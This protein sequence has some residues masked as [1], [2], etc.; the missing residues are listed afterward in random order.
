MKDK[1]P[2]IRWNRKFEF[3]NNCMLFHLF[4]NYPQFHHHSHTCQYLVGW[5]WAILQLLLK[6]WKKTFSRFIN[7]G[8]NKGI[9]PFCRGPSSIL[10][11][12]ETIFKENI[13]LFNIEKPLRPTLTKIRTYI[14]CCF[15]W[16]IFSRLSTIYM[17][18]K[19]M[20]FPIYFA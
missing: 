17:G 10:Y 20:L 2:W 4:L 15:L 14:Q 3:A 13:V 16:I 1:S 8:I 12:Q 19:N 7:S 18:Y 11:T 5:R 6:E 9:I